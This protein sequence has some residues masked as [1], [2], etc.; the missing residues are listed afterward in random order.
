MKD[1]FLFRVWNEKW[2]TYDNSPYGEIA[3][4]ESGEMFWIENSS[5]CSEANEE[6][7]T[8]EQCTGLKDK[9]GKLIYEGDLVNLEGYGVCQV[10]WS[11]DTSEFMFKNMSEDLREHVDTMLMYDWE[12][13]NTIHGKKYWRQFLKNNK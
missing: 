12:V 3:L 2:K 10:I 11:D 13:V 9:D 1:R 6:Y 5:D 7:F 8:V 4:T